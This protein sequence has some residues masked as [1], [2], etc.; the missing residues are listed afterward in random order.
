[1]GPTIEVWKFR[2]SLSHPVIYP[3]MVTLSQYDHYL[4]P[5][6]KSCHCKQVSFQAHCTSLFLIAT[7]TL[8]SLQLLVLWHDISFIMFYLSDSQERFTAANVWRHSYQCV[9][10]QVSW[11]IEQQVCWET[12]LHNTVDNVTYK[13]FLDG[14]HQE[15][16]FQL[17]L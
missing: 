16:L 14:S 1:M 15:K 10:W 6:S 11:A 9:W 5:K 12:R 13:H 17:W 2:D 8:T 3:S 7:L 4:K